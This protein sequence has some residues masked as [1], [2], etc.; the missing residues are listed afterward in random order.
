MLMDQEYSSDSGLEKR[1]LTMEE[2]NS[3]L[4]VYIKA[5]TLH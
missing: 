1:D 3:S 4:P 2:G 5:L